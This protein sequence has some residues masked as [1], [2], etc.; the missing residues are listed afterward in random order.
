MDKSLDEI[1]FTIFDT[2]TTGLEPESGD[3]IVEIAA[4]RFKQ[5]KR[6]AAFQALVNPHRPISSAAFAV[7]RISQEMLV[8]APDISVI[9]PEFLSFIKGSCLC[10]YNAGFDL[11]FLNQELKLLGAP[12]L[13]DNVVVDI[14]KMAKRLLP[15]LERYALWFVAD[16]LGLESAQQHRALSDVELT[17]GV[18]DKLRAMLKT[19]GIFDLANFYGLFGL[20][21][22][23]L[24]NLNNQKISR[25][26]EALDLGLKLKI[27]Y[28]SR[29]TAQ[30]SERQV[31]PKEIKQD[32][33][34]I[35]L[36][37]HCCLRNQER[38]FRIDGILHLE[39][40]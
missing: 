16:K 2:E 31:I 6:I 20:N 21:A 5:N 38:S 37:G 34:Y 26:Q 4:V 18:F 39:A 32:K 8:N 9:M 3:R 35:Y 12:S 19:K 13:Q 1:E 30:V 7:N 40:I 28:L 25:I 10:S 27:K 15:G 24:N 14:L 23:F 29:S 36:I 33:D 11:G 22:D 17:L